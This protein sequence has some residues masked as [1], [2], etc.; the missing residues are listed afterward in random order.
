MFIF[1]CNINFLECLKSCQ[2]IKINLEC[3]L[4]VTL[5]FPNQIHIRNPIQYL[6]KTYQLDVINFATAI[7][8]CRDHDLATKKR[9]SN[10]IWS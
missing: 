3:S 9:Q 1:I 2:I 10:S 6:E 4:N 7:A 8:K 5:N